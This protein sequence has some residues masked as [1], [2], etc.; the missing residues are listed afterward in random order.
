[1]KE[2]GELDPFL[3]IISVNGRAVIV[4]KGDLEG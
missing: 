1:M 3:P 2:F 4:Q